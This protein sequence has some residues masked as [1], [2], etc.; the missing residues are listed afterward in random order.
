[1]PSHTPKATIAVLLITAFLTGLQ[2]VFPGVLSALERTPA[3]L[4]SNE[5]WGLITPILIN[6][7]G[8]KEITFNFVSVFIV[9]T[10]AEGLGVSRRRRGANHDDAPSRRQAAGRAGDVEAGLLG[11]YVHDRTRLG[12][13][14]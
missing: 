6:R 2:S 11:L 10:I 4:A 9:G 1:M 5:W 14:A 13:L 7:G 12:S 3:A 8:W